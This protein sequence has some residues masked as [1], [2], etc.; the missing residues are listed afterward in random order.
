MSQESE[1]KR[2]PT[3]A[4]IAEEIF[5]EI[6]LEKLE[7]VKKLKELYDLGAITKEEFER[8]YGEF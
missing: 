3:E 4:E 7:L 5:S 1:N 8:L 2:L 6:E